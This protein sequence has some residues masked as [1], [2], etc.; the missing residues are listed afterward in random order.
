MSL[1]IN[2]VFIYGSLSGTMMQNGFGLLGSNSLLFSKCGSLFFLGYQ[3]KAFRYLS[4]VSSSG[5]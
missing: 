1:P 3:A 5:G 4:D 2:G